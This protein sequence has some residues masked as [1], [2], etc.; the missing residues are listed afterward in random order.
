MRRSGPTQSTYSACQT[1]ADTARS[2][3]AGLLRYRS[4]RDLLGRANVAGVLAPACFTAREPSQ[5]Q[6]WRVLVRANAVQ[7]LCEWPRLSVELPA[8]AFSGDPR[9]RL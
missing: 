3:E 4:V 8:A 1:L 6:T 5:R 9:L 2:A 7:A